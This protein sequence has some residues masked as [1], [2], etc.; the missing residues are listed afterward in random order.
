MFLI[1][2]R[3]FPPELGGIQS[4]MGG[5]S[6]ALLNHGPVK[7]FADAYENSENFD[8]GLKIDIERVSGFKIF[9]KYR[10][11][12][13]VKDFLNKHSVRAIFFDH[14]KS[15]ENISS[16]S[17][18]KTKSFCLI[19]SKEINHESKTFLNK[20][21]ISSLIK[22]DHI[23]ANSIFTKNLAIK[24]GVPI[25][26][27]SIINPGTNYPIKISSKYL[28]EA[29][30]L[31]ENHFPKILTVARLDKRKGHQ[32]ILMTIKNLKTQFPRLK[33]ISI[34]N[35]S[36]IK[37]L[38]KL[39]GELGLG[40]EVIFLEST[41]EE[42]K[43]GLLAETNLFLMPTIEYKKSVE[44]F[45]ISFIE[46]ASYGIGSIGGKIG[47]SQDAILEGKTGYICDGDD[48]NSI[49]ESVIKFF[50]NDNYKRVGLNALEFSKK[51][52]WD[53][54]VKKYLNLI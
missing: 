19:H 48:L 8:R 20:R 28:D 18:K 32:N 33:Y 3:N 2:T 25:D 15:I 36:E 5:L 22:A 35:G 31:Y 7:V 13:L 24:H 53:K 34:G 12:N 11:A 4:L 43:A 40:N 9:R 37:N 44:G 49:Y 1:S 16:Q 41:H 21:M 29:K 47:G 14:W 30:R 39:H 45:G 10:K 52:K 42:L 38:K 46:A 17:L 27:I 54:I 51:F 26:K 6:E 50:D 23:V